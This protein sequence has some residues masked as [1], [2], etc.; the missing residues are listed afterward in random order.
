MTRFPQY[1]DTI[2]ER[3]VLDPSEFKRVIQ[4]DNDLP[5]LAREFPKYARFFDYQTR[6]EAIQAIPSYLEVRK[7]AIMLAQARRTGVAFFADIPVEILANI[8]A[9]TKTDENMDEDDAI[10]IAYDN[11]L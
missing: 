7:N 1:A 11:I 10:K 6:E 3:V 2:I 9:H 4:N 8:A 5:A